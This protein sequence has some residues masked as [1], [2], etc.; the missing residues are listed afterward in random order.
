MM[1]RR[2]LLVAVGLAL[3]GQILAQSCPTVLD[4]ATNSNLATFS[5]AIS[6]AGLSDQLSDPT[7]AGTVFAPT[8]DAFT[9]LMTALNLSPEQALADTSMLTQVL[10][11]LDG[12]ETLTI[13]DQDGKLQIVS[14]SGR[15]ASIVTPNL[16]ACQAVVQIVDTVLVPSAVVPA[17]LVS[18]LAAERPSINITVA[19]APAPAEINVTIPS[20]PAMAPLVKG[21]LDN[22]AIPTYTI[23]LPQVTKTNGQ[24]QVTQPGSI[25]EEVPISPSSSD[26][27]LFSP[28]AL[29]LASAPLAIEIP[30]VP[31]LNLPQPK[32]L[33]ELPGELESAINAHLNSIETGITVSPPP[34]VE[35]QSPPTETMA[36]SGAPVTSSSTPVPS[37]GTTVELPD[38]KPELPQPIDAALALKPAL[39]I[40]ADV[41][42][43]QA[44]ADK[45]GKEI[46]LIPQLP[47]FVLPKP[48]LPIIGPLKQA[49]EAKLAQNLS[50]LAVEAPPIAVSGA[51]V[52]TVPVSSPTAFS[53]PVPENPV[54][55][56]KQAVEAKLGNL[57]SVEVQSPPTAVSGAPVAVTI[58]SPTTVEIPLPPNPIKGVAYEVVQGV[59]EA[60]V[61]QLPIKPVLSPQALL[62]ELSTAPAPAVLY[63]GR[64][65]LPGSP[66]NFTIPTNIPLPGDDS[67]S[68]SSDS[69]TPSGP[70]GQQ[71][72]SSSAAISPDEAAAGK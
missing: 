43:K 12:N 34:A 58:P 30:Q 6:T 66:A 18:V 3:A 63:L 29:A 37:T 42:V 16:G 7:F 57:P 60:V 20:A 1:A 2:A 51:P 27:G 49:V 13:S 40:A 55:P 59:N 14:S 70:S 17:N 45:L 72:T 22:T 61:P 69:S 15:P 52:T 54:T 24:L 5:A 39:P 11:T 38:L 35:V 25:T 48:E 71:S 28:G 9:A 50:P 32:G 4:V 56:L 10:S 68:D 31:V 8:D 21:Q 64:K 26:S 36:V 44:I 62:P 23:P 67:S 65:D 41:A 53:I 46:P 47:K 19:P 33:F